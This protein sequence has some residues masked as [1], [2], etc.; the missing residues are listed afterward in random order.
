M[1]V[2]TDEQ[3]NAWERTLK[4][5]GSKLPRANA[6][7]MIDTIR[8]QQRLYSV[9]VDEMS[10]CHAVGKEHVARIKELE[11]TLAAILE[12]NPANPA[13][14]KVAHEMANQALGRRDGDA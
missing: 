9:A 12:L 14:I 3:I 13:A 11:R 10:E 2:L 7:D 1:S 8:Y 4:T 5:G 6:L